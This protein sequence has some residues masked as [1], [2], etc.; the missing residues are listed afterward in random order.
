ME[1]DDHNGQARGTGLRGDGPAPQGAETAG[2]DPAPRTIARRRLVG[3]NILIGVTT[4]ILIVGIFSTWANRLLFSPDNWSKTS[5]E[6]LQNPN[7]RSTTAN[8]VVDQLYANVDV[9][10]LLRSGLP[11][12]LDALA[13]PAAGA[14][15]NAAVQATELALT[16]PVIQS[17]WAQSNRAA[18]Q[19]FIATVEGGKGPVG[20]KEGAV[21]LNLGPIV[22]NV[23]SRLG[24]P[25]D[26]S[27]KL[28]PDVANLTVFKAAQLRYVQDGGNA[29]RSLAL[30]LVVLVPLL[31]ALALFL[32]AGHRRRTLMAIGF[33]GVFAGV[34]VLLGRS[35][36]ESQIA[37]SLTT[38]ASL[39]ATIRDV[40]V[41]ASSILA[42]VAG[43]VIVG[44]V[45]LVAAAWFAGPARIAR[46]SRE[47]IAP[48]LREQPVA[49]YAITLGVMALIFIWN[50]LPATG[51]PA[52]IIVFTLLA[53][54]GTEV[55]IRQTAQE[56]PE[57][58]RGAAGL[59]ISARWANMRSRRHAD[60][61]P[62]A[63]APATTGE[64]LQQLVELRDNGEITA[65]EYQSA[66][67]RILHE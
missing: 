1:P 49:S 57:A 8:Y 60:R 25:S 44:G 17:L 46:T 34:V 54:V 48:F 35:I 41:I 40:Y 47:A 26:L 3:V 50:P 23:A 36:L 19:A 21:T 58:R 16:R 64:Q 63:P 65:G 59:A 4:L 14:L 6:L 45:V 67:A 15:R 18:A 10:G 53:L 29:I 9:A 52:G 13:A 7:V 2:T 39:Q 5:T 51:K 31:Y 38:D 56:F 11:P 32:A 30:W 12:Q 22:D 55:L 62:S 27:S 42:D 20:V 66:K 33:S 61:A 24:L 28:T 43:A 37:G